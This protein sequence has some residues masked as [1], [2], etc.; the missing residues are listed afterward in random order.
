VRSV[1][2]LLSDAV[3]ALAAAGFGNW[4]A[5]TLTPIWLPV[6]KYPSTFGVDNEATLGVFKLCTPG[7]FFTAVEV[8]AAVFVDGFMLVALAA[9]GFWTARPSP[10]ANP[11]VAVKCGVSL[12]SGF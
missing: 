8:V 3:V 1:V 4:M 6:G 7:V 9:P 10:L 2:L 11:A 5:V 12:L